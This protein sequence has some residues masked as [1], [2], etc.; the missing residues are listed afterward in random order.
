MGN[1]SIEFSENK[2]DKVKGNKKK[3]GVMKSDTPKD[4]SYDTN[5]AM[6][7]SHNSYFMGNRNKQIKELPPKPPPTKKMTLGNNVATAK[8]DA[9]NKKNLA[10]EEKQKSRGFFRRNRSN[11]L[12]VS[13]SSHNSASLDKNGLHNSCH[14]NNGNQIQTQ[15]STPILK[16]SFMNGLISPRFSRHLPFT[17]K[18]GNGKFDRTRTST[19]NK[20]NGHDGANLKLPTHRENSTISTS[21]KNSIDMSQHL[22]TSTITTSYSSMQ[23]LSSIDSQQSGFYSQSSI[24][25]YQRHPQ[26]VRE[27][28]LLKNRYHGY[29]NCPRDPTKFGPRRTLIGKSSYE[30]FN[31]NLFLNI[32]QGKLANYARSSIIFHANISKTLNIKLKHLFCP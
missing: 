4:S 12:D 13:K 32:N 30:D 14:N 19:G 18:R 10:K 28:D 29:T 6:Q 27:Q 5:I 22:P 9:K 31:S 3:D 23:S 21:T 2:Y 25:S 1:S 26:Y 15:S 17:S 7:A 16:R 8:V 24:A 11:S 20:V